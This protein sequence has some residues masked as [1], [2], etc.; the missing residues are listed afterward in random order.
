MTSELRSRLDALGPGYELTHAPMDS[1]LSPT[2]TYYQILQEQNA[3][4]NFLMPQ[5]RFPRPVTMH[6]DLVCRQLTLFMRQYPA[7]SSFTT[8]TP[9][10][11][12]MA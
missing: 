3:N 8:V 4:L 11:R 10:R 12:L 7:H 1:D 2:S 6:L 9:G 5:V